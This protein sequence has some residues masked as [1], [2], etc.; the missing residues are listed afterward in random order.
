MSKINYNEE[1]LQNHHA[2]AAVIKNKNGDTLMMDHVKFN[3]WTIPVGKVKPNETVEEALFVEMKEELNIVPTKFEEIYS[4]EKSYEREGKMVEV[5][6]HIFL[7]E[8]FEGEPINNEP[9]KHREIK[10]MN[11]DE[12]LACESLSD[13]TLALL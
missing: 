9:E 13:A 4:F 7:V 6:Q 2:V 10:W 5:I 11:F 8:E 1:D 12:I 3:F